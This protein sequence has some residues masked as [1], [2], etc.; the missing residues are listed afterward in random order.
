M[1]AR[2]TEGVG[3]TTLA[4]GETHMYQKEAIE[5]LVAQILDGTELHLAVDSLSLN[6]NLETNRVLLRCAVHDQRT[7]APQV[8]D[9][10][11]VGIVDAFFHGLVSLYAAQFPSLRTVRFADFSLRANLDS[12]KES[13]KSD[14][15]AEVT[16]RIANSDGREFPFSHT[17][18]SITR[19]AVS[20]TLDAVAFFINSERAFIDVYRALQHARQQDRPDSVQL[21]TAQLATLVEATSYSDVIA[22]IRESEL[23][24]TGSGL[25]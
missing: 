1:L 16:L 19:S 15:N 9:G 4:I 17:S 21:Y 23:R 18:P 24:E 3:S 12:A 25:T 22:Q 13:A 2:L 10:E 14:S 6:E 5:K 8:I 7:G 11:G 20:A